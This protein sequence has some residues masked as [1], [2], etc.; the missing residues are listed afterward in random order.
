MTSWIRFKSFNFLTDNSLIC[1]SSSVGRAPALY[2]IKES[3]RSWVQS[4]S[5]ALMTITDI[6]IT[7]S[8]LTGI[9]SILLFIFTLF[10]EKDRKR[11]KI[12]LI[13]AVLFLAASFAATEYAFWVEGV[14]L[15]DLIFKFN[16]PLISYFTIWLAFIVWLFEGRKERTVWIIFAIALIL[17]TIVSLNCPNCIRI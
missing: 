4:P 11:S 12:L 7:Y 14:Y 9:F 1:L 2:E 3:G 6:L 5:E 8:L 10:F 17:L 16:F 13:W 15:F